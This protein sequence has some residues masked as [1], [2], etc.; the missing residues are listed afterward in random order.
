MPE[1]ANKMNVGLPLLSDIVDLLTSSGNDFDF[2]SIQ[3]LVVS[4][5]KNKIEWET[6]LS[7]AVQAAKVEMLCKWN[8]NLRSNQLA[9]KKW[10]TSEGRSHCI[11]IGCKE[12]FG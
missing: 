11:S 10:N 1:E 3:L 4:P 12:N 9:R 7:F 6:I 2:D 8:G 5:G